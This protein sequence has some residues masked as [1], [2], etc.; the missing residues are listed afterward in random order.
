MTQRP[1]AQMTG[2]SRSI[3]RAAVLRFAAG[4]VGRRFLLPLP[5]RGEA[6]T[7]RTAAGH[8]VAGSSPCRRSVADPVAVAALSSDG[9]R[10]NSVPSRPWSPRK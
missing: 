2:G 5:L 10:M 9:L 7:E 6:K 1:V 3:G 8:P 4:C